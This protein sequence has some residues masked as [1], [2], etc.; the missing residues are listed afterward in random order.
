MLLLLLL[1]IHLPAA[2]QSLQKQ[3]QGQGTKKQRTK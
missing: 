3:A 2:R 1:C